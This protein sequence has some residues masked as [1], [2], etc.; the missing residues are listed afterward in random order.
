L[1][2]ASP[3]AFAPEAQQHRRPGDHTQLVTLCAGCHARVHRTRILRRWL[4]EILVDLW[5]EWHPDAVEQLR[6]PV[7]MSAGVPAGAGWQSRAVQLGL[8]SQ[9]QCDANY[10]LPLI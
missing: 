1:P 2:A 6:L 5:R 7:E 4:P 9:S 3:P 8:H 10:W